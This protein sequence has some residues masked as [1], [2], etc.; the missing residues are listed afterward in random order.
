VTIWFPLLA[1]CGAVYHPNP[2]DAQTI[3]ELIARYRVTFLL[4]TP[5]FCAA[6][7]R[8]CRTE[9]FASL[10]FVLV[11]AEKLRAPVAA[12]FAEKFGIAPLEGYGCTE[13]APVVA[14]NGPDFQAGADSQAGN[15]SGTVG[16][17]LPGVAVQV[18]DPATFAPL[19][20]N[21]PGLL[22]VKGANRMIGYLGEPQRT[23]EALHDG[24]YITGD[25]AS[26]DDEGFIRLTDRLSRFSKIAGEMVPH[27]R[28][29]DAMGK[30]LGDAPCAVTAIADDQRGERL[31]ALY[32]HPEIGPAELWQR[33]ADTDLPRLWIPKRENLYAV[34]AL[35]LLGTGKLDLRA[36]KALAE[37][38]A[39]VRA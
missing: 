31:V 21:Q 1:G 36:V 2:L 38:C 24:W 17:P 13:M 25:V 18:V 23:A 29:E 26:I 39:G 32:V 4:S 27:L 9:D 16:R 7:T 28:I 6:Y 37:Q 35:P 34:D 14:V 19:G 12:A 11:G 15:R 30:V 10:R 33:L 5:T 22:L 8:K 3:G 20:A